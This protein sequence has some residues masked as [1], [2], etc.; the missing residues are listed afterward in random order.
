MK[1]LILI[2]VMLIMSLS[3]VSCKESL[4]PEGLTANRKITYVM[5]NYT[6]TQVCV[7]SY[8]GD[9]SKEITL[10][11]KDSYQY[12][13][14]SLSGKMEEGK[15]AI[16]RSDSLDVFFQDGKRVRLVSGTVDA[17]R[18]NDMLEAFWHSSDEGSM[19]YFEINEKLKNTLGN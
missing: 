19:K 2:I 15:I 16:F 7:T 11:P 5:T 14:E 3:L 9:S 8:S 17:S 1:Q 13:E 6:D 4:I 18:N 12:W 10:A